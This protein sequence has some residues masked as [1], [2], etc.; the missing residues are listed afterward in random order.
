MGDYSSMGR[1]KAKLICS[2]ID[3]PP[4]S[5]SQVGQ[6]QR[7]VL[8]GLVL[9]VPGLRLPQFHLVAVRIDDPREL[10]VLVRFRTLED[11]DAGRQEVR[12]KLAEV[13]DPVVDH[14]GCVA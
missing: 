14:E 10:A 8:A 9:L 13:I 6:T 12:K 1:F 4:G 3:E 5:L 11:L 7:R 2:V